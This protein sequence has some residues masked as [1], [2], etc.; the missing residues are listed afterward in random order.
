MASDLSSMSA[1]YYQFCCRVSPDAHR[2]ELHA[3]TMG[4]YEASWQCLANF[5][6]TMTRPKVEPRLE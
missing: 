6:P 5:D 1:V 2:V 3:Y 4:L